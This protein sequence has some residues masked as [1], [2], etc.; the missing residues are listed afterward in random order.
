MKSPT[1]VAK[2]CD[3]IFKIVLFL[4]AFHFYD[5]SIF[6]TKFLEEDPITAHK[7]QTKY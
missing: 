6:L 2:T 7:T 4:Q 1:P 5:L 3:K